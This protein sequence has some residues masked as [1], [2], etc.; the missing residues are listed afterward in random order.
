MTVYGCECVT[1]CFVTVSDSVIHCELVPD[2]VLKCGRVRLECYR[3]PN[4]RTLGTYEEIIHTVDHPTNG[5][6]EHST[7]M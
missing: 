5:S 2:P 3:S 7:T 6:V 1:K 4:Y